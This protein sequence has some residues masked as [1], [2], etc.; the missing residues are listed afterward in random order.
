MQS[1]SIKE[2]ATALAKAQS[3][4]KPIIKNCTGKVSYPGRDGK[5]GGSY[6]FD[7]ADL[8]AII[9][10]TK[11]ALSAN[12]ISQS[13]SIDDGRL[14]VSIMH[15]SGE[16]KSST[17]P[18]PNPGELGWQK[19]GSAVTYG[20]RYLLSPLLGVA[21]EDDDDAN[22]AEGNQFR[23]EQHKPSEKVTHDK[24]KRPPEEVAKVN[25]LA[26]AL[27]VAGIAAP[28]EWSSKELGRPISSS[29]QITAGELD[30][31]L[32][33]ARALADKKGGAK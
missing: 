8:Q 3:S 18:L 10:A 4:Y 31:L 33:I 27:G 24:P 32:T 25:S 2:L 15:S 17:L 26:T 23:K 9:E 13:A 21:S 19:F 22:A 5:P 29:E 1:D 14:V 30:S 20:R 12:G 6:E 16:W 28:L 7:Y 11:D